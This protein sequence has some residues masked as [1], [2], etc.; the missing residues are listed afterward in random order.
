MSQTADQ[1]L[2]GFIQGQLGTGYKYSCRDKWFIVHIK[3]GKK[4]PR[5]ITAV[6][7]S[8]PAFLKQLEAEFPPEEIVASR[9]GANADIWKDFYK[10]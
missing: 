2:T 9:K 10:E 4:I 8:L 3:P 6:E 1:K 7:N 5:E